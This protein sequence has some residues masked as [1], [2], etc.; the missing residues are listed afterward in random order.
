M[1]PGSV[2]SSAPL[3][4]LII[5]YINAVGLS[6]VSALREKGWGCRN[7]AMLFRTRAVKPSSGWPYAHPLL[8]SERLEKSYHS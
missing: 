5:V 1:A 7:R 4:N 6:E 3:T 8:H 2:Y